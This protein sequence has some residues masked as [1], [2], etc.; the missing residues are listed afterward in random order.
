VAA[1]SIT[2]DGKPDQIILR[3]VARFSKIAIAK[4]AG[5]AFAPGVHA[6]SDALR[7]FPAV[8]EAG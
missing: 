5:S 2:S 6:V 8:T 3:R 1:V 7:C 4:L